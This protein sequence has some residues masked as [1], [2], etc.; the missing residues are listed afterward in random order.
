MAPAGTPVDDGVVCWFIMLTSLLCR[1]IALGFTQKISAHCFFANPK[2]SPV[3]L[4]DFVDISIFPN[5]TL[6]FLVDKWRWRKGLLN[7]TVNG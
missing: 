5:R 7:N 1:A 3:H 2:R 4:L 6:R